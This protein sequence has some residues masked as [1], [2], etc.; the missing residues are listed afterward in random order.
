MQGGELF[1]IRK[2]TLVLCLVLPSIAWGRVLLRWTQDVVPNGLEV[3]ELVVPCDS[4]E[5]SFIRNAA[6]QGYRVYLECGPQEAGAAANSLG[7]NGGAGIIV[8]PG[9]SELSSVSLIVRRLRAAHPKVKF[10][11]LNPNALPPQMKGTLVINKDGVLHVTSPT[12]QP[13]LDTN[14]A[15]VKLERAFRPG[16]A[17]LT[18]GG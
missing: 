10:L 8:S 3:N 16:Q 4:K 18:L 13:W 17:P 2:L 11:L 15:L 1:A 12:A 14:L 7:K 6:S 5:R 9:D